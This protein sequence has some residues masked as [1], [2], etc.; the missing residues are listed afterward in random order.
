MSN[1]DLNVKE[2]VAQG[3]ENMI[4]KEI[5][6]VEKSDKLDEGVKITF[7]D[8]TVFECCWNYREGY[9]NTP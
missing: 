8:G 7:T 6:K 4:G 5:A 3:F 9:F 1:F 2:I